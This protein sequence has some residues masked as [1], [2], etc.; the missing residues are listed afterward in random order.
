MTTSFSLS[1]L[2]WKPFFQQQ[3]SLDE[4]EHCKPVRVS[5]VH[6]STVE[7]L[8]EQGSQTLPVLPGLPELTVGDWLLLD[9]AEH[10]VRRLDRLTLFARKAPGQKVQQQLIAANVDT[11]FLVCSMNHDFNLSRI[12]RYLALA[13][14]AGA[15]PVIVLTKQ[16]LADNPQQFVDQLRSLDAFLGIESVNALDIDSVKVLEHWCKTG[17][18]VAL[19]GSSGVG[20]ST[21][22][23]T[24]LGDT[25]QQTQGIREDDSKGRHTTTART[26]HQLPSGGLL[27]D[28]PGMR[29]LQLADCEAGLESTFS[30]IVELANQCQFADC[31]H[32]GEPGCAVTE[33]ITVGELDQRRVDNYHKLL[34]EQA[35]N[36][37]S[38]AE[39]RARDRGLSKMYRSVQSQARKRK[40]G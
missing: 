10:V 26:L 38:L 18:T 21:L 37:E 8:T 14:D 28:T 2:G 32:Q 31:Q 9:G 6:R 17:Q 19:L 13:R 1:Q 5:A 27:L 22:V 29:E 33:A 15:E 35:I 16:D 23:N 36:A 11:V 39:K 25:A 40:Q 20:K 7:L 24:L 34:R 12:E 30:E 4:W 3:L